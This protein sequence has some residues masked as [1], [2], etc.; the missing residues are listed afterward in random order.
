[1]KLDRG[2]ASG[3]GV[4]LLLHVALVAAL[5]TSLARMPKS[6]EPPAVEVE[7]V[8]SDEVAM[9]AAAPQPQAAPPPA[10]A[11][12]APTPTEVAPPIPPA[13]IPPPPSV[14]PPLPRPVPTPSVQ[15]PSP[16]AVSRPAPTPSPPRPATPRT[17]RLGDDFLKG[18]G[19]APSPKPAAA[20]PTFSA[21]A[22]ASVAATIA[23]Q[24]QPCA[25]R[26]PYLGEGA[27][28]LTLWV[29]LSFAKSGTLLRPPVIERTDGP[30]DLQEKYGDLLETQVR[31]I[32]A[33]CAPFR[34]PP[35]LY[36][37]DGGGWKTTVLR[38]RV[39]K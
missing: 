13:P 37:T 24:A 3:T 25:D 16:P 23:R 30:S 5:T 21:A 1:V 15:K 39:R 20:A 36:D 14:A 7:F 2:E 22:K 8:D 11:E 31:G 6:P 19:D 17:S 4:A 26:K 10:P 38:Y 32:F 33:E 18:I 29:R 9:T 28:H 27:D 34:L 35:E 12:A